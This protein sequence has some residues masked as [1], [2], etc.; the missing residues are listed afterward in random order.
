MLL[1]EKV[2]DQCPLPPASTPLWL[3][4]PCVKNY[5]FRK[6][7]YNFAYFMTKSCII[8]FLEGSFFGP[9][10]KLHQLCH[11]FIIKKFLDFP[12]KNVRQASKGQCRKMYVH[13]TTTYS[14]NSN[15][16]TEQFY[17]QKI[18]I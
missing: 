2:G 17:K 7:C 16:E 6:Q 10:L 9:V 12:S 15:I 5:D 1:H 4:L 3:D 13:L 11:D 18:R 8:K 14:T